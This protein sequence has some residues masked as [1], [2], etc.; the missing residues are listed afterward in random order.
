MQCQVFTIFKNWRMIH[1]LLSNHIAQFS[2]HNW[3]YH[4]DKHY[5]QYFWNYY[6]L[7]SYYAAD[8]AHIFMTAL[9]LDSTRESEGISHSAAIQESS[10]GVLLVNLADGRRKGETSYCSHPPLISHTS[11]YLFLFCVCA[12]LSVFSM[13]AHSVC[14]L[15]LPLDSAV[16][17]YSKW[18][19]RGIAVSSAVPLPGSRNQ[20]FLP[21]SLTST[22]LSFPLQLSAVCDC[23]RTRQHLQQKPK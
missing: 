13:F 10:Q 6:H 8:T 20:C 5:L 1:L 21:R 18:T 11:T 19:L 16:L 17:L 2:Q 9:L 12:L 4:I 15:L 23:V 3:W 7:C 14:F 22:C